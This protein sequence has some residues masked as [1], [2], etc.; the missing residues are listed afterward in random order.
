MT[1]PISELNETHLQ[2]FHIWEALGNTSE[3]VIVQMQLSQSGEEGQT[4]ILN[5]TD[6]VKPKAQPGRSETERET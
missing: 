5:V 3:A 1:D 6:V 2:V 4:S